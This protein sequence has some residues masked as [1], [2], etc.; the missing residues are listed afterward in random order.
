MLFEPI[1][2]LKLSNDVRII[3][4]IALVATKVDIS[5]TFNVYVPALAHIPR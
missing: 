5:G 1:D 3:N 4:T 2:L